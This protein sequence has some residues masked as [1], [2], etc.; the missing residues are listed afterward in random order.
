[1]IK[2]TGATGFIGQAVIKF[3]R[4]NSIPVIGYSRS[5]NDSNEN[6]F[7][8]NDYKLIPEGGNLIHLG[9][10]NHI[11]TI[12]PDL[13][14]EHLNVTKSLLTKNFTKIVYGSSA[15]VYASSPIPISA[16]S[17]H[18]SETSYSISK[19]ENEILFLK[20]SNIVARISNVYGPNM[21]T[22]N[23]LSNILKQRLNS[24]IS[25][26]NL[27]P[28]RDYIW[29]DD[30][31]EALVKLALS[32][33]TGVYNVSTG[34][35]TSVAELIRIICKISNNTNFTC[36]ESSPGTLSKIVLDSDPLKL[37]LN[38]NPSTSLEHGLNILIRDL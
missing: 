19:R 38:W 31:A 27:A 37:S 28:I 2:V 23:V 30:V 15:A 20:S 21:S 35:G 33:I 34:Q 16:L 17:N 25:V 22:Y 10:H 4:M 8:I 13:I 18:F 5:Q 1:M 32:D 9:E 6:I 29:V 11:G 12:T 3:C 7:Q 36:N 14:S 26:Q 24:N